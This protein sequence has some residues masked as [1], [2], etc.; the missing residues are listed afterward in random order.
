MSKEKIKKCPNCYGYYNSSDLKHT[1][2]YTC[3]CWEIESET[4]DSK[5]IVWGMFKNS[6][7]A[8]EKFLENEKK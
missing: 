6:C 4:E 1:G 5:T 8:M 2:D 3:I 7:K